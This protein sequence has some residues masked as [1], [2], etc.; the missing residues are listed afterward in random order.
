MLSLRYLALSLVLCTAISKD[1]KPKTYQ[2]SSQRDATA[3][4]NV[5]IVPH[6]HDD[7]GWLKTVDQ[8]Y[9]GAMNYIQHAN[10]QSI[11]TA[12]IG[13]LQ[14]NENRRFSYVEQAFFQRWYAEQDA[15]MQGIVKEL[16]GTGQLE[17]INGAWSMHDEA[18]P[19]FFSM[20]MNTE[21]GQRLIAEE[22][23]TSALPRVTWQIDPFGHSAFNA[24]MLASPLSG[25][26][27]VYFA[28]A[29]FEDVNVRKSNLST[30]VFWAPSPSLG[31]NS[32][33]IGGILADY[34]YPPGNLNFG[35]D[36]NTQP[37]MDDSTLED[38]NVDQVVNTFL[39]TV[40]NF[41][42]FTRGQDTMMMMG[43]DFSYENAYTWFNNIDKLIHYV[44]LNTSIHGVHAYYGTPSMY[45]SA[46]LNYVQ[47]PQRYSDMMPYA[48]GPHA[49]WSGYFTS[50]T[51]LKAYI[52]DT[53][54]IYQ[55]M[56]GIQFFGSLPTDLSSSNPLYRMERAIGVTQHHDAVAGTSKQAVAYDYALRLSNG[57]TDGYGMVNLAY[58]NLMNSPNTNWVSCDLANSTICPAL[59][60]TTGTVLLSVW[61]SQPQTR[62]TVNIRVPVTLNNGVKSWSVA[63]P[64]G[65][66]IPAQLVPVSVIDTSLRTTYYGDANIPMSWL[67]FQASIPATGYAVF[68]LTP[69]TSVSD[70]PLT[71]ISTLKKLR[72][73]RL[74]GN[75]NPSIT[76]GVV[77]ITFD[78]T[79]GRVNTYARSDNGISVPLTQDF[80]W[81][82]S[83][84]NGG[85]DDKTGDSGQQSGAYIFRPNSS[86]PFAVS[87]G[88]V[89]VN[90]VTGP[91]LNEAIQIWPGNWASQVIRLY[92]NSSA[93]EFEW[94][95]GPIPCADQL[96]KEI[97]T[98]YTTG[99]N[100]ASTFYTDSNGRDS[101][102][103]VRNQRPDWNYTVYEPV[104]SNY[105]PVNSFI[106]LSDTTTGTTFSVVTDR[107]NG[108]SSMLDGSLELM[109]HRR[110]SV[111]DNRGVGEPLNETGINGLG[112]IARGVHHITLDT[113][114]TAGNSRRTALQNALF[115]SLH[116]YSNLPAGTSYSQ[117]LSTSKSTFSGLTNPLPANVH[118]LTTHAYNT[119]SV[120]IRL[121]HNYET[122]EDS[123]LSSNVTVSLR[124]LFSNYII[125]S[126]VEMTLPGSQ[127]LTSATP[128]TYKLD[129][130]TSVSLPIIPNPPSGATMDITLGPMEIRTFMCTFSSVN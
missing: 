8:Y 117:W 30:E 74:S 32:A 76:N 72:T 35:G 122:N 86:D 59:E 101:M 63:G 77:T 110:L 124:N 62:G 10:V 31:R 52:R 16:V 91:I 25:Y 53:A 40:A 12:M 64:T 78:A 2:T 71:Y 27:A 120:L 102:K 56:Q 50:R 79:T 4:V 21:L 106:Y 49:V 6:T 109:V 90:V 37:I 43:T 58:N 61:N 51:A 38:Y 127:P 7:V 96:G 112:L 121:S 13:E 130:G 116:M 89:T 103:R 98:R 99:L 55:A 66:A 81:Y 108:G 67:V 125:T 65:A 14:K 48:D 57:R 100:S 118:L 45:T 107:S 17:F 47:W 39:S 11:I 95:I 113:A 75:A 94:T 23:G 126:A 28:R 19:D 105:Y 88:A 34:Y 46:K 1:T 33:T 115:R 114:N 119:D 18:N 82:N 84:N 70:A 26:S 24:Y 128:I 80:W 93:A 9:Y 97:I 69:S 15:E 87:S 85:P 68:A 60:T 29:D 5:C 44:N 104:A 73:G 42:N 111:D 92:A 54:S 123:V 22:F 36:D 3:S 129:D 83:S 20:I 41:M